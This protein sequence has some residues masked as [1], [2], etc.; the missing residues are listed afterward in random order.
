MRLT[1]A[2]THLLLASSLA[3]GDTTSSAGGSGA[4]GGAGGSDGGGGSD[5]CAG[6]NCNDDNTCTQDVC[7]AGGQCLHPAAV[8]V[9]LMQ[10][11]GDCA[12]SVCDGTQL[13]L[14]SDSN[15]VP[16]DDGNECTDETCSGGM[17]EHPAQPDG[18][19]C[20]TGGSCVGGLCEDLT[21]EA[22]GECVEGDL[23]QCAD[24]LC[25]DCDDTGGCPPPAI[26]NLE[27]NL[28]E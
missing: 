5:I 20:G 8:V 10:V 4:A 11:D 13:S 27:L 15:D 12:V 3:C 14:N 24:G 16:L 25:V 1:H 26:C 18:T 6:V 9:T 19:P 17:P 2:L 22:D 28:C 21:C 23:D 7:D